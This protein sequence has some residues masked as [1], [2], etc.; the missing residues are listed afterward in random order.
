[1]GHT[2]FDLPPGEMEVGIGIHGEP[3]R[4]RAALGTAHDIAGLM[5]EAIM[6][7]LRPAGSSSR[8]PDSGA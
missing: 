4:R 2:L 7:D 5:V 1:M 6:S 8:G 3:G